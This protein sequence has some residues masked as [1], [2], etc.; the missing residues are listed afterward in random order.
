MDSSPRTKRK[1]LR[2]DVCS[3]DPKPHQRNP[4]QQSELRRAKTTLFSSQCHSDAR[5]PRARASCLHETKM[6]RR[7]NSTLTRRKR[8]LAHFKFL[9]SITIFLS[10]CS[11]TLAE[12]VGNVANRKVETRM[13]KLARSQELVLDMGP[14][15]LVRAALAKREKSEET[16]KDSE[17]S[18]KQSTLASTHKASSTLSSGASKTSIATDPTT[19]FS[20]TLPTVFDSTIGSNFTESSCPTFFQTFLANSTFVSCL[21]LSLLLQVCLPY[22]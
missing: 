4:I 16:S 13:D 15:P 14:P 2:S 11:T 9:F 8:S 10:W 3:S 22:L 1:C 7:Q 19:T 5:S 20:T 21:P 17:E 6:P 18:S 12:D